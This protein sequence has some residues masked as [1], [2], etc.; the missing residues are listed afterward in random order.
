MI[1]SIKI[2]DLFAGPGG[3]GEGF[4]NCKE[5]SPFEIGMSVEF[6][7]NAH[8]TLT[9]RA[10]YRK[11]T[12]ESELRDY[13]DYVQSRNLT[14]KS[15]NYK[16]MLSN[17]NEKWDEA[18]RETLGSPHALGNANR[19]K[20]IK[21]GLQLTE[22]DYVP[23]QQEASI[24]QRIKEIK[25]EQAGNGPLIV[26]GGPPCQAY[27]VNGRNRIQAEKGYKPENDERFF[28]YLEYLKVLDVADP[29]LFIMENVEG[30]LSAKLATG[31]KIFERIKNE[32]VRPNKESEE[33]Y[34]IFSLVTEYESDDLFTNGPQYKNDKAYVIN[35][36]KFGV[37]QG[38]KRVIL[39][40]L[41]KKYKAP[42]GPL[43]S[44]QDSAPCIS[45]L[46][47][48]MPKIRTGLSRVSNELNNEN[49]WLSIWKS[50]KEKLMAILQ[51]KGEIN[52]VVT[53]LTNIA[54]NQEVAKNVRKIRRENPEISPKEILDFEKK[55]LGSEEVREI[56]K[57]LKIR[58]LK[59]ISES[60]K[61]TAN[62]LKKTQS[63]NAFD[64]GKG[65]DLF[66]QHSHTAF[67]DNFHL[68]YPELSN[69]LGGYKVKLD[70][71]LNHCTRNNM[72][73]DLQRYMFSAS[74][75]KAHSDLSCPSPRSRQFPIALSPK[76]QNWESGHHADRFRVVEA[77]QIPFTITSHLRKDGHAQIHYD[78]AQNRSLSVRE[79]AR[80]Q[81]FPDSYYFEGSQGWQ[82]QQVGNAVPAFLAKQIA[83]YVLDIL[84]NNGL[85]KTN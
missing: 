16:I 20:K 50:N 38:R 70:G 23:T 54:L 28:L 2:I 22:E 24:F 78:A 61:K 60:F 18:N 35:A 62:Q 46:I 71:I 31:E 9:L 32:L 79:A 30:I 53:R 7:E 12:T 82:F 67:S 68:S 44:S 69:W 42:Q 39:L 34:N 57:T 85:Y 77:N 51:D 14:E 5:N 73:A 11:L 1:K 10:F 41:K 75:A 6:E 64:N 49:S 48:E 76:H 3:L 83:N 8:K 37:P 40:G 58:Y 15:Q 65:S 21:E 55:R 26:I 80:I 63:F 47:D 45:E 33:Q 17:N 4:S 29:D 36:R 59:E 66:I 56:A 81:T 52:K 19:W 72:E 13:K 27:S 25:D 74:W 84:I 43:K